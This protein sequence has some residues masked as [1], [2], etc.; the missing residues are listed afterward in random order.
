MSIERPKNR[1]ASSLR[2]LVP[3]LASTLVLAIL[4]GVL[5]ADRFAIRMTDQLIGYAE[6]TDLGVDSQSGIREVIGRVRLRLALGDQV[7]EITIDQRTRYDDQG[8]V[9][10]YLSHGSQGESWSE[11]DGRFDGRTVTITR[12]DGTGT[13]A[14]TT[15]QELPEDFVLLGSNDFGH[16]DAIAARLAKLD[17]D[18]TVLPIFTPEGNGA[19]V[20]LRGT[21]VAASEG[22]PDGSRR[23]AFDDLN[24][25]I[26]PATG[27]LLA[28]EIPSQSTRIE[29][30]DESI[31]D[32]FGSAAPVDLLARHFIRSPVRFDAPSQVTRLVV[33]LKV[34]VIGS[35]IENP[36]S[37]LTTSMQAFDGEKKQERINGRLTVST[38]E[39]PAEGIASFP[40]EVTDESLQRYLRP[41]PLIESDAD[42]IV[43]MA[44]SIVDPLAGE[45]SDRWTVTE[46]IGRWT[47]RSIR[48]RIAETPSALAALRNREGDCGPHA[49]L[50]VAMLRS[51]GIPARLVGGLM[52]TPSFGG[53]FGQH[54][55][56]EVHLGEAGWF[57]FDPT[58]G[59]FDRLSA[60]HLKL[61]E[62]MGGVIPE[63]LEVVEFAP[64]AEPTAAPEWEA[65]RAF[66]YELG[67]RY[68]YEYRVAGEVLGS[69]T[70]RFVHGDDD[71]IV[72]EAD[73]DLGAGLAAHRS[74]AKL[75]ARRDGA[76][77]RFDRTIE[78]LLR[79]T[80]ECEFRDGSVVARNRAN[81]RDRRL[82]LEAGPAT[83]CFDNNLISSF[84]LMGYGWV[85]DK[86]GAFAVDTYHASTMT[87]LRLTFRVGP[88][89][90]LVW[91]DST[92]SGRWCDVSPIENRF[93]FDSQGRLLRIEQGTLVV[94]LDPADGG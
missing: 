76:V 17:G 78:G 41:E 55:W 66:P 71:S 57:A 8:K 32:E 31:V 56:V 19:V 84:A 79:S 14:E 75:V 6:V 45:S 65:T 11:V 91:G 62:G 26:D 27:R 20:E 24:V 30:A 7:R 40:S 50:T 85:M 51:L 18:S 83:R 34:R 9:L 2:G 35:G 37:I 93:F 15:S 60:T 70:F 69:E 39:R 10:S 64:H 46:A 4:P 82:E 92:V 23:W 5:L 22:D 77:D 44:R 73:V 61:F 33:D 36:T 29:R 87:I 49:T 88:P 42:E 3:A 54:A 94:E 12:R 48:Y 68:R 43:A 1:R 63:S 58:T 86:E 52:Y 38:I 74:R 89:S 16:F 72:L 59:E 53:S 90:E 25:V 21:R 67:T 28:V 47:F 80:L 13:A 81:L